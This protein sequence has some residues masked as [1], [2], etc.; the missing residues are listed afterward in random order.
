[1]TIPGTN[2]LQLGSLETES[3]NGMLHAECSQKGY[4]SGSKKGR[5]SERE[6]V[7]HVK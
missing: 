1:M 2:C 6:K 5:N 3:K 7:I 4:I